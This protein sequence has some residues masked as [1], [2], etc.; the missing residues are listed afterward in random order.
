MLKIDS[1]VG[2]VSLNNAKFAKVL[3]TILGKLV[4]RMNNL[5]TQK[6]VDTVMEF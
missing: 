1:F 3:L 2:I 4:P 5:K 6:N